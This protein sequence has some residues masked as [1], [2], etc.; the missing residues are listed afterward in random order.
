MGLMLGWA[1]VSQQK[2]RAAMGPH[3]PSDLRSEF[4][5]TVGL[6]SWPSAFA[7]AALCPLIGWWVL[8]PLCTRAH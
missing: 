1:S 8:G 5:A 3:E 4:G 6:T 7:L 2:L